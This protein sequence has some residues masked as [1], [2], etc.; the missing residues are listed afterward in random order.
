MDSTRTNTTFGTSHRQSRSAGH[1]DQFSFGRPWRPRR[2]PYALVASVVAASVVTAAAAGHG[3]VQRQGVSLRLVSDQTVRPA[4][5]LSRHVV[6]KRFGA[7]QSRAV[8][9]GTPPAVLAGPALGSGSAFASAVS[10]QGG[11]PA[12][13][14][15]P[16]P[17]APSFAG[18][19]AT[20]GGS[21]TGSVQAPAAPGPAAAV[22]AAPLALPAVGVAP[23]PT[24]SATPS[25]SPTAS[26]TPSSTDTAGGIDFS[27]WVADP[28]DVADPG[29]PG[30]AAFNVYY[31]HHPS[32]SAGAFSISSL[33]Y[34]CGPGWVIIPDS[35]PIVPPV[36]SGTTEP[37]QPP[38]NMAGGQ[39]FTG[40]DVSGQELVSELSGAGVPLA[41]SGQLLAYGGDG[42]PIYVTDWWTLT[43]VEKNAAAAIMLKHD[44]RPHAMWATD[45][46][47]W[48]YGNIGVGLPT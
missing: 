46:Y 45:P 21:S 37:F 1:A 41:D 39:I 30:T 48:G 40:A 16:A 29:T 32:T 31:Q 8:F 26:P 28:C 36:W 11:V 33:N 4:H 47:H 35:S 7:A 15:A 6:L 23:T 12:G 3:G 27:E 14:Q 5:P 18:G 24:D 34:A 43:P 25:S 42:S 44:S 2:W 17:Q 20:S 22:P 10:S 9:V 13:V 38:T 19:P